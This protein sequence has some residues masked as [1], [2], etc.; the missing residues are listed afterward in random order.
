[1]DCGGRVERRHC[2]RISRVLQSAVAAPLCRRSPWGPRSLAGQFANGL[3]TSSLTMAQAICIGMVSYPGASV[4]PW[5][6]SLVN[7]PLNRPATSRILPAIEVF[8]R[9]DLDRASPR[10][11]WSSTLSCLDSFGSMIPTAEAW[12]RRVDSTAHE[13]VVSLA[14]ACND[15]GQR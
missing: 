9:G 15:R 3:V 13:Q 8:A 14:T 10:V 1:M 2:F 4:P 12:I 7:F 5:A 11:C 6:G